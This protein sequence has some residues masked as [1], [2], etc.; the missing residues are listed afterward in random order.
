MKKYLLI[1]EVSQKQSFIFRSKKL[2]NNIAASDMIR[3]VTDSEFYS[4]A[5]SNFSEDNIV[6]SGGGHSVL[7][8]ETRERAYEFAKNISR[9]IREISSH[10]EMFTKIT[11]IDPEKSNSENIKELIKQLEIKKSIRKASFSQ[12]TFGVEAFDFNRLM[13]DKDEKIYSVPEDFSH[14]TDT[15]SREKS[16]I[17][18]YEMPYEFEKLGGTKNKSNFIAVVHIDGNRMGARVAEFDTSLACSSYENF[19]E[20][21]SEKRAFSES[22]DRDFTDSYMEMVETVKKKIDEGKL[23]ALNLTTCFPVRRIVMAGD[24]ICFVTEGRIGIECA[25]EYIRILGTKKNSVDGKPYSACA[26]VAIVH[27]KY[28]FYKAYKLAEELCDNAKRTAAGKAPD[29]AKDYYTSVIDWHIEYGEL[30]GSVSEQRKNGTVQ[31]NKE[32]ALYGRPY[33]ISSELETQKEECYDS[34]LSMLSDVQRYEEKGAGADTPLA[35]RSKLK[36]LRNTL[37]TGK[38]AAEEYCREARIDDTI[39]VCS[40]TFDALEI[41]DTFIR[42]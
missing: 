39:K 10:L 31:N 4:K 8:F 29:D 15:D 17:G 38:S 37:K 25:A 20:Y 7:A 24:D 12:G 2:K 13:A 14:K 11:P 41:M 28:P 16:I 33:I 36:K 21:A 23:D 32:F 30:Y 18:D 6:Y 1:L 42:F 35:A 34:F 5:D 9:K 3:Y 26:G 22:I 40:R 19:D 27:N